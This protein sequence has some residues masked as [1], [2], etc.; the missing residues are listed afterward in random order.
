M[1]R[2][3]PYKPSDLGYI[4]TTWA[5]TN[6]KN[7]QWISRAEYSRLIYSAIKASLSQDKTYIACLEDNEDIIIGWIHGSKDL[8]HY[9]FVR[10]GYRD[11][12]TI[13]I[14]NQLQEKFETGERDLYYTHW[15]VDWR[16]RIRDNYLYK[17]DLFRPELPRKE[18]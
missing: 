12:P 6:R 17:P 9:I 18:A 10:A 4:Y 5:N 14:A 2:T 16:K 7:V 1:I 8:I 15:S 13:P 11:L 3:R